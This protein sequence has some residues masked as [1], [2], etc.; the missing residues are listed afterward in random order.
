MRHIHLPARTHLTSSSSPSAYGTLSGCFSE[1]D[2]DLLVSHLHAQETLLRQ[3]LAY[4]QST[5][6]YLRRVISTR[7][8]EEPSSSDV[9]FV[10]KANMAS[11]LLFVT[12]IAIN[13]IVFHLP[14][15]LSVY[16]SASALPFSFHAS[17]IVRPRHPLP[18]VPSPVTKKFSMS[19]LRRLARPT[20]LEEV[21]FSFGIVDRMCYLYSS[22]SSQSTGH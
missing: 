14:V 18:P 17:F 6:T 9:S 3:E 8:I 21:R 1:L 12:Q 7:R 10:F 20:I 4:L 22:S 19:Y 15:L 16:L 11:V 13:A 2:I 5:Q